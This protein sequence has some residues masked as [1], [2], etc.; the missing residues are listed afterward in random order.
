MGGSPVAGRRGLRNLE[1]TGGEQTSNQC[2]SYTSSGKCRI[3]GRTS[4]VPPG[5]GPGRGEG[6]RGGGVGTSGGGAFGAGVEGSGGGTF[7]AVEESGGATGTT[8]GAAAGAGA[9][10]LN[11][12]PG[13]E[14]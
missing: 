11:R 6:E 3:E 10:M 2:R 1:P 9:G 13:G 8:L 5:C 4:S 14:G 12:G 7:A